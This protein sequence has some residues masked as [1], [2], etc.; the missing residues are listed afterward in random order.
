ME[1]LDLLTE[2]ETATILQVHRATLSRWR[3][4]GG[5][6]PFVRLGPKLIRYRRSELRAWVAEGQHGGRP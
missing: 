1:N 4:R 3:Q 2:E 5:G 6:P